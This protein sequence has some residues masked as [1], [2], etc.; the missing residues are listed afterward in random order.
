[1]QVIRTSTF[2]RWVLFAD[3]ATCLACGLLM[4]LGYGAL[5][6][7]LGLPGE[8]LL[9]AGISLLPFTA[10]LIY[11]ATRE[12]LSPLLVWLVIVL[13]VLWAA[14]SFLLLLTGWVAPTGPGYAIVIVQALGVAMF[15][16][17]EY[18]SLRKST[19]ATA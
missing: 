17:L 1:M 10:Y 2:L 9:Y 8:L 15:A 4:T 13:N 5:A 14:D 11:L 12:Y 6:W 19:M 18:L 7:F 3:A 16:A